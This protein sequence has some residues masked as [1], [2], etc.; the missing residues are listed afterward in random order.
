MTKRFL[1]LACISGS[2]AIAAPPAMAQ[3]STVRGYD[4][5][6][7]VIG[8]LTPNTGGSSANDEPSLQP[9]S[10]LGSPQEPADESVSTGAL[11]FTGID[12][13]ILVLMGLALLG[14]GLMLRR[15]T[16]SS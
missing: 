5:S 3:S 1:L 16:S 12:V 15:R 11:P 8:E 14:T 4:E 7:G 6:G 2:L 10:S 9:T 13:G